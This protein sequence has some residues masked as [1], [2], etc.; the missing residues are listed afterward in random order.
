[1]K[2]GF[3]VLFLP[4]GTTSCQRLL[5]VI[6]VVG[7]VTTCELSMLQWIV[8]YIYSCRQPNPV[9]RSQNKNKPKRKH[10]MRMEIVDRKEIGGDEREIRKE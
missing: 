7:S 3:I 10:E 4:L 5:E 1:M 8:P 6:V 2:K 9:S